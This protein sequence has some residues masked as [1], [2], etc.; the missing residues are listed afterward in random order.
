MAVRVDAP[1]DD[2]LVFQENDLG[3]S[4]DLGRRTDSRYPAVLDDHGS[5]ALYC[6][7]GAVPD[8]RADESDGLCIEWSSHRQ[9][10]DGQE[11]VP[12]YRCHGGDLT[13]TSKLAEGGKARPSTG[14]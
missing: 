3:T 13:P 14:D 9:E 1:R 5:P 12:S 8:G 11:R 2:E 7:P 4:R 10:G 6:R